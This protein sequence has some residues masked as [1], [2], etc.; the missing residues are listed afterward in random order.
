VIEATTDAL[1]GYLAD[2]IER[3]ERY[4]AHV[5][6]PNDAPEVEWDRAGEDLL[7][8]LDVRPQID[9]GT[10][11][12]ITLQERWRPIGQDRW[13]L[14]EYGYE[15]RDFHLDYRRALHQHDLDYFV[16]RFGVASH[17][18]CEAVM[19]HETCGHYAGAQCYGALDGLERLYVVWTAGTKPDCL[20]MRCL[21]D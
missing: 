18:H 4:G 19:G 7:M 5:Q 1:L 10:R 11:A 21:E 14:A 3:A 17:E 8:D 13:E 6:P 12:Q 16:R 20:Q 15:L 2:V 9:G